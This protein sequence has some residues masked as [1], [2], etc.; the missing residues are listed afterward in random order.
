MVAWP[1]S[2]TIASPVVDILSLVTGVVGSLMAEVI[3]VLVIIFAR[4]VR[5]PILA[6]RL[7]NMLTRA[8]VSAFYTHRDDYKYRKAGATIVAYLLSA[9]KT[10]DIVAID[11]TYGRTTE[12]VSAAIRKFITGESH[13]RVRVSL[14]DPASSAVPAAATALAISADDLRKRIT[15]SLGHQFEARSQMTPDEQRR[16]EIL[17]HD[18]LPMGSAILLDADDDHEGRIQIETKLSGAPSSESFG[19]EISGKRGTQAFYRRHQQSW[20]AVI[21]RSRPAVAAVA[22]PT[23]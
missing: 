16:F 12:N 2:G 22:T 1:R 5:H 20:D 14:L 18:E 21:R 8:G 23:Q 10:I 15:E 11:L 19:F 9:K 6:L 7:A 17:V 4:R 3:I 13:R